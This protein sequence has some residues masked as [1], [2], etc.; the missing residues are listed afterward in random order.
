V[1]IGPADF[2]GYSHM[3]YDVDP[4]L[5]RRITP[6]DILIIEG[7]NL[8]PDPGGGPAPKRLLDV[9]IYIDARETDIEAWFAR[10]FLGH[11]EAA[12]TDLQSFYARFN[13][14][15]AEQ[16]AA[17]AAE[18]W[19]AINLPNLR[20]H[21]APILGRADIIV[22]KGPGHEILAISVE[23]SRGFDPGASRA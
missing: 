11:C 14:L 23:Q 16:A 13:A 18:V 20:T 3:T 22:T 19:R 10:R 1:R 5:T 7:L 15:S 17:V 9:L 4:E 2:P 12:K 6:P 8:D 21:I